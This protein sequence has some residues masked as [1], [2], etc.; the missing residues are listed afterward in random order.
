M[1][2][3]TLSDL[4][5]VTL[6]RW[7][8]MSE[9]QMEAMV[10]QAFSPLDSATKGL[11]RDITSLNKVIKESI[12]EI[13]NMEVSQGAYRYAFGTEGINRQLPK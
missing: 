5:V 9:F 2:K 8:N 10:K 1:K 7:R 11:L 4:H 12:N 6:H 3:A 13:S